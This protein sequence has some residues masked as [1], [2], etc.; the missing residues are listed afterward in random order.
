M[1]N[2]TTLAY[3]AVLIASAVPFAAQA[4]WIETHQKHDSAVLMFNDPSTA[5]FFSLGR[6]AENKPSGS[7]TLNLSIAPSEFASTAP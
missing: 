2:Y 1:T 7:S 3:T 6:M 5:S 4:R